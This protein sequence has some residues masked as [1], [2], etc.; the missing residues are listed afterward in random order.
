MRRCGQSQ[1]ALLRA[2]RRGRRALSS[3]T[4]PP[5]PARAAFVVVGNEVL[6]GKVADANTRVLAQ[7]LWECGV[8]LVRAETIPD[9]VDNIAET[10]RRMSEL[11][12]EDGF[13]FTSGGI[14]G[15]H[16]DVTYEGVAAAF[17]RGVTLHEPTLTAMEAA[18]VERKRLEEERDGFSRV[19]LNSPANRRMAVLPDPLDEIVPTDGL[20]VPITRVRN[21]Y[22]LPGIPSYF[23]RMLDSMRPRMRERGV[24][25]HSAEIRTLLPETVLADVM[26]GAEAEHGVSVGSY[27]NVDWLP[28]CGLPYR[29][30]VTFSG[31]DKAAVERAREAVQAAVTARE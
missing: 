25:I 2:G 28:G 13:V 7:V 23:R 17:G 18:F 11:A 29:T 30:R 10:V 26:G 1:R 4:R 20:W 19:V 31:R 27:P 15:T 22:S 8:D 12:G 21:V 16:D 24:P 14:G 9:E 6:S 5:A 3:G